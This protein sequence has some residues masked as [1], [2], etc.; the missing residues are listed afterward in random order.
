M[1]NIYPTSIILAASMWGVDGVLLRP[2]LYSLP[3]P[4]V[5]LIES[6]LTAILLTPFMI[7]KI[8]MLKNLQIKDW[9]AFLGVALL[10]GALG[11]MAITRALFYVN[12]VNLSIVVLIQ[13]LQPIFAISLAAIALKERPKKQFYFWA[14]AAL[15]GAY[16]TTFG[17][18]TPNMSTGEKTINAALLALGAAFCF[19][20]STALSKR[21]LKN[22]GFEIGTYLRFTLSAA[23]LFVIVILF[24]GLGEIKT[25][26]EFQWRIFAIIALTSGGAAIFLYY[27]GLKKTTASVSTI[28]E[29]SFPLTAVLLEGFLRG[30][31]LDF[32]QWTGASVLLFSII[33]VSRLNGK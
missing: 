10:G 9:L 32:T 12:Y 24:G 22:V 13:K 1:K 6:A 23:I 27:F 4:L 15:I 7:K 19:G 31:S 2:Y 28:C 3:V 30:N 8:V 33:M 21:A 5:V 14:F 18:N 17:I 26:T 20:A 11:T 25:A 29:L 16:F